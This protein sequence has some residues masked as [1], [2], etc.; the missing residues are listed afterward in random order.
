PESVAVAADAGCG[1]CLGQHP[2]DALCLAG[3]GLACRKNG[4]LHGGVQF[5]YR[6][7]PDCQRLAARLYHQTIFRGSYGADAD[8]WRRLYG[9]GRLADAVGQRVIHRGSV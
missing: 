8:D 1:H 5:L 6:D 4:V 2:D 7:S 3:G 9:I